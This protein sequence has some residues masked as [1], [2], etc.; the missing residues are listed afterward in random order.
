MHDKITSQNQQQPTGKKIPSTAQQRQEL[1]AIVA[2]YVTKTSPVAPLSME[3][4]TDHCDKMIA[5]GVAPVYRDYLA[6]LLNNELWR[7]AVA[8]VPYEKR[9]LLLPQCLRNK[10]KC[11]AQF[12]ELGLICNHCGNCSIAEIKD[13]AE[14]LGYAVL[15]AEGSPVVMSLIEAG[16]IQALIGVSCLAVLEKTF[17]SI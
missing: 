17:P 7:D 16:K 10:Q 11:T 2:E 4:I 6:I 15:V 9:L 8:A 14:Q 13:H 1:L 5:S 12:D 3:E